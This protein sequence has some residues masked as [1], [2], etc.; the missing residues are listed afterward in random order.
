[1]PSCGV[2][3][4]EGRRR[5]CLCVSVCLSDEDALRVELRGKGKL[6]TQTHTLTSDWEELEK[7]QSY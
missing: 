2:S 4:D 3:E 1:M 6:C 5:Y 7:D